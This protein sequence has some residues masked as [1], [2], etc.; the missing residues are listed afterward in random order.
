MGSSFNRSSN[1]SSNFNG[2]LF[3]MTPSWEHKLQNWQVMRTKQIIFKKRFYNRA[4]SIAQSWMHFAIIPIFPHFLHAR[5]PKKKKRCRHTRNG[6]A[7]KKERRFS[8]TIIQNC[9]EISSL[10]IFSSTGLNIKTYS[11]NQF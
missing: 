5:M 7:S 2:F 1:R 3:F 4:F 11:C 10:M 8:T 9:R 6:F